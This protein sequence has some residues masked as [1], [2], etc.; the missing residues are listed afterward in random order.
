MMLLSEDTSEKY[1]LFGV[2]I[3]RKKRFKFKRLSNQ[4]VDE[5]SLVVSKCQ[6]EIDT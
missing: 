6:N 1:E 3:Q 2:K 4:L 5:F